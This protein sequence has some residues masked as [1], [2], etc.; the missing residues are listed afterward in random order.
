MF[1]CMPIVHTTGGMI[2]LVVI[3]ASRGIAASIEKRVGGGWCHT[4]YVG[5]FDE[6]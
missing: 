2:G 5:P 4:R 1:S 3:L 6:T